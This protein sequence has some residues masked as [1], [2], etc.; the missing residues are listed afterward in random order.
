MRSRESKTSRVARSTLSFSAMATGAK[1][2]V[3][4]PADVDASAIAVFVTRRGPQPGDEGADVPNGL[5]LDELRACDYPVHLDNGPI[6]FR[7]VD[8]LFD[9][10]G[11][12][13]PRERWHDV[14]RI[15]EGQRSMARRA[16]LRVQ[17][18]SSHGIRRCLH[19]RR[20]SL[21][22]AIRLGDD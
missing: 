9:Q 20:N 15:T 13:L 4:L 8:Q 18:R 11:F 21:A 1:F 14:L 2:L 7:G 19:G 6:A 17:V 16:V 5:R 22:G 10:I 12:M 3:K